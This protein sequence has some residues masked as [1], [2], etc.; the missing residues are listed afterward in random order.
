MLPRIRHEHI[1]REVQL[2]GCVRSAELARKLGVNSVTIRRDIVRLDAAGLV[3]RVHG[4]AL[5]LEKVHSRPER[6]RPLVGLMIP[7]TISYFPEVVRGMEA[8][9][10]GRGVRLVLGVSHYNSE[11]ERA[12]VG[13]LLDLGVEGLLL[14][15]TVSGGGSSVADWLG[16]LPV[17]VVLLERVVDGLAIDHEFEHV[18]TD[19]RH[20]AALAVRHLAQLGH[21]RIGLA[22]YDRTPTAPWLRAGYLEAVD[23]FGIEPGPAHV[24]PKGE[25]DPAALTAELRR[26][27]R[28]CVATNTG[29]VLAHTDYH[30]G[31]LVEVAEAMRVRVPGQFAVVAYDDELAESARVPL[32]AV[33]AP[34]LD[35]GRIALRLLL[36]RMEQPRAAGPVRH[37]ELLPRLTVRQSC[38]ARLS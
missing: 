21:R 24:L 35:V 15:P 7:S 22:I 34:R 10:A 32:T 23:R 17:P 2:R 28:E 31:Q 36:D 8:M 25:E 5:A 12:R 27:V 1:L 9:A 30:A 6:I 18:R 16:S 19:H 33:T 38:G 14:A 3:A 11:I 26:L 37:I 4:G 13:R 29:A 20:G